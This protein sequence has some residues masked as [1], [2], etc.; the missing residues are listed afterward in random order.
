[1][2]NE[3]VAA[4]VL[5]CIAILPD[6]VGVLLGLLGIKSF[7]SIIAYVI[8]IFLL[9]KLKGGMLR[10]KNDIWPLL[11]YLLFF[12][13]SIS[14]SISSVV[15]KEKFISIIFLIFVQI[16][17]VIYI[18]KHN[19]CVSSVESKVLSRLKRYSSPL[20]FFLFI[21]F[22][23]G[24]TENGDD[25]EGR[26]TIIGTGNSIWCSRFVGFLVLSIIFYTFRNRRIRLIDIAGLLCALYIMIRCGS[27]GPILS[28]VLAIAYILFPKMKRSYKLLSLVLFYLVYE[29]FMTFTTRYLADGSALDSNGRFQLA[30]MIF[31]SNFSINVLLFG[32]GIG[33]Y[34][35]AI[36]GE[37]VY[38]YPH[39]IFLETFVETGLV[40]VTIFLFFLSSIF[41]KKHI[42]N[43]FYLYC[44]YFFVNALFSGDIAGNNLFFV[45][46]SI[47][48]LSGSH[49]SKENRDIVLNNEKLLNK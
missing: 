25:F 2:K 14:Y 44:I 32:F 10:M 6:L 40:G 38:S 41:K 48:L 36:Q 5:L 15:S 11:L 45:F 27:R 21:L 28:V 29:L 37:D 18:F 49:Y 19:I 42:R 46:A 39:N 9:L 33:G 16:I 8:E 23:M 3:I 43:I 12:L 34:N 31:E 7:V 1:M 26:D 30:T 4:C 24:F 20:L 22:V 47:V 35:Y 13:F 17:F